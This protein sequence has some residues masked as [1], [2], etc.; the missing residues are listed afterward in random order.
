MC[1]NP[2]SYEVIVQIFLLQNLLTHFFDVVTP[3]FYEYEH[4]ILK[5]SKYMQSG[6]V[7]G[8]CGQKVRLYK[9]VRFTEV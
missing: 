5:L 6:A 1:L 9:S 8:I 4:Y 2:L 7:G 3:G